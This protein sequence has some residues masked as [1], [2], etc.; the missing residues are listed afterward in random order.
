MVE[1]LAYVGKIIKLD[2][3][4][5]ADNICSATVVCG[6]GGRWRGVVQKKAFSKGDKCLVCL[7]DC[8]VPQTEQF[9]FMERHKWRVKMTRFKGVASE[10]LIVPLE[11]DLM[12]VGYDASAFIGVE[13]YFKPIPSNLQGKMIGG[14]PSFIPKTDEL[15][16][17]MHFDL[18]EKLHGLPYYITEKA[19]GSSTTAFKR[20][21][22]FGV[23]S[24]NYE[25]QKNYDNGY[26]KVAKK[27]NVEEKLPDGFALQ[28]ETCGPKIQKNP[29]GFAEVD[30][31]AFSA[32][33]I[34]NHEYL[35]MDD[36]QQLCIEIGFPMVKLI[37]VGQYFNQEGVEL[38]G[39]GKYDNG[40]E[41][42][43]VVVRSQGNHFGNHPISFKV[44]NLAYA[45]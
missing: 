39:E 17:Q 26:W 16:Y 6:D 8:I 19:D 13:R 7:P 43:G 35:R 9:S 27:Y 30:G 31:R 44:I 28:W 36:F 12:E 37:D 32:Y 22:Q 15:N 33:D 10:V 24:R 4:E 34:Y 20:D 29:M 5:G 11:D 18:V 21:G 3:I 42:E 40:K 1:R 38:L 41:R 25:L 23:C 45:A 2:P 14:F